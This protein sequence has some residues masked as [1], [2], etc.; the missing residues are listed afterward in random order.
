VTTLLTELTD[1]I[2]TITIN[3][4]EVRNALDNDILGGIRAGLEHG[5]THG[6]RVA[7]LTGA[8]GAFCSGLNIKKAIAAGFSAEQVEYN[9]VHYFHPAI[10]AIRNA[11][12]PVLAAVDGYAGGFGNDLALACDLRLVS[13]RAKFG[14]LFI[15]IGLIPDGGGTYMLPRLVGLGRAMELMFTGRDVE[16]DEALR[17]GLANQVYETETFMQQVYGYAQVLSRQ[18]PEA[19]RRGK[20]LM[21]SALELPFSDALQR[22]AANQRALLASEQGLEGMQAFM[23]KRQPVW[24]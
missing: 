23:E 7:I 19:L 3:A 20:Q 8:G 18:S 16:A 24:K 17:I 14:E 10:H 22:E 9:L 11:P 21:L 5:A 12:F 13:Q 15:R 2:I 4:P 1:N 6:A